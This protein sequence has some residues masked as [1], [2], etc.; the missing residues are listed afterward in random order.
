MAFDESL[1]SQAMPYLTAAIGAY[2]AAV[3]SRT[4]QSAADGTVR[5]G[6]ELLMSVYRGLRRR[7]RADFKLRLEETARSQPDSAAMTALRSELLRILRADQ[8]AGERFARILGTAP[9][10]AWPVQ[11]RQVTVHGSSLIA[12]SGDI[13]AV[14]FIGDQRA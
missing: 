2:G 3:L 4:E 10:P 7:P 6:K 8:A 5:V 11:R 1:I 12:T 9:E 14:T 13:G